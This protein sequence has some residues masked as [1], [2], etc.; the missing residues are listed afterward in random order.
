MMDGAAGGYHRHP[1]LREGTLDALVHPAPVAEAVVFRK[2]ADLIAHETVF[3]LFRAGG[4]QAVSGGRTRIGDLTHREGG[5]GMLRDKLSK[6]LT[7]ERR[8][9]LVR[10][11]D[12]DPRAGR[13]GYRPVPRLAEIA[14]PRDPNDPGAAAAR[15]IARPVTGTCIDNDHL[16]GQIPDTCDRPLDRV[17]LVPGDDAAAQRMPLALGNILEIKDFRIS[18]ARHIDLPDTRTRLSPLVP[19]DRREQELCHTIGMIANGR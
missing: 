15:Q 6:G 5:P 2:E 3:R 17:L 12:E 9:L 13:L 14:P 10:V 16:V 18:T 11:E 19:T 1:G 7:G 8:Q 4:E